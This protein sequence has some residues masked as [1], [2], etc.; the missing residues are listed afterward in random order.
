MLDSGDVPPV[1]SV[2]DVAVGV[3]VVVA[4]KAA[5]GAEAATVSINDVGVAVTAAPSAYPFTCPPFAYIGVAN[6]PCF[7]DGP[8]VVSMYV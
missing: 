7:H 5:L 2:A 4:P 3:A 6:P 8:P 1:V